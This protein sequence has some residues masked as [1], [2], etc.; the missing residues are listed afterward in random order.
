M[1]LRNVIKKGV[2]SGLNPVRWVGVEQIKSNGKIIANVT[3]RL[4]KTHNTTTS[5]FSPTT[6][7]DCMKYYGITE[8]SLK[9]RM[10]WS[11]YLVYAC[12]VGSLLMLAYT[13]Y[14]FVS[15]LVLS[16]FVTTMLTLLLWAY[17][18]RE[19]FNYFQMKQRRLGC[20]FHEWLVATFK[21]KGS[22]Q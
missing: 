9:K 10:R 1:G 15:H 21:G 2:V 8:E 18:F 6:F 11:R 19:H 16:G 14:L 20:T 22:K 17:A 4:F 7:E 13:I 12:L 3:N 5:T